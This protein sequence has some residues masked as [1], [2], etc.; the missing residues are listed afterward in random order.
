MVYS[1]EKKPLVVFADALIGI[2]LE[3]AFIIEELRFS[4]KL[5]QRITQTV[6]CQFQKWVAGRVFIAQITDGKCGNA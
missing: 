5:L 6:G 1:L 2:G 4:F 3:V